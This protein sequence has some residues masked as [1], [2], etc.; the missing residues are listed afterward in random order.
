MKNLL[1]NVSFLEFIPVII[2]AVALIIAIL[3]VVLMN[4]R[5]KNLIKS[6]KVKSPSDIDTTKSMALKIPF[7]TSSENNFLYNFQSVLPNEYVIYPKIH[8]EQVALPYN[9]VTFYNVVKNKV[10]DYVV[11]LRKNMQPVVVIDVHDR[12]GMQKSIEEDDKLLSTALANIGLPIVDYEIRQEY[13]P[14][15]LLSR[16]LDALDPLAIAN[17]K[18]NRERF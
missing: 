15:E 4:K 1:L 6:G 2:V 14:A 12:T 13:E 3:I 10:L 7:L 11:F 17:L 9:N 16:F 8:V 5:S 18:K